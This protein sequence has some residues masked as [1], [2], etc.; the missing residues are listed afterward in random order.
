VESGH[1]T[2]GRNPW[3]LEHYY[4]TRS[5]IRAAE[6]SERAS[7]ALRSAEGPGALEFIKASMAVP[8]LEMRYL[9]A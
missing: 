8:D 1:A 7:I 5:N 9:A 3:G 4:A 6:D 2:A